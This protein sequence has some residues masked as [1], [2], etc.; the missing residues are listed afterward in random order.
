MDEKTYKVGRFVCE[1][2]NRF[3]CIVNIDGVYTECYIPSSCRLDN[4]IKL[5]GKEVLLIRNSSLNSR[6]EYAVFAVKCKRNYL[7]LRSSEANEIIWR[8]I[9]GRRFAFLGTRRKIRREVNVE[10]YKADIFI[11]DTKTIIEIKSIISTGV[12]VVFPT[13]YSERAI[14]QLKKIYILLGQGY[15]IDYIFVSLNPYIRE[16][17]LSNQE[18]QKEFAQ[19]FKSC[20]DNGMKCKG[21]SSCLKNSQARLNREVPVII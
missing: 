19:I 13:V 21:Y 14:N 16:I 2:K 15:Q 12:N 4:F 1:K 5:A 17:H 7:I 10:G 8:D 18:T 11:E 9:K 6:T 3:L 20:I